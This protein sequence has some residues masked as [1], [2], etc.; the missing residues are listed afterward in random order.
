MTL[1]VFC[2]IATVISL[3]TTFLAWFKPG[4]LKEEIEGRAKILTDAY[5][6]THFW[7]KASTNKTRLIVSFG[8]IF[9]LVMDFLF[10]L[11]LFG[12]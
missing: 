10:Y 11:E 3:R 12:R 6:T 7:R 4:K 8:L 9:V 1:F 5:P 2:L